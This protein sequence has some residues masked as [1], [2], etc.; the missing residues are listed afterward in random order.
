MKTK[1]NKAAK[2][3]KTRL[4]DLTPKK[5]ARGGKFVLPPPGS[6]AK[7]SDPRVPPYKRNVT[8]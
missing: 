1:S 7:S 6:V 2:S 3:A 8:L 4:S 5:D